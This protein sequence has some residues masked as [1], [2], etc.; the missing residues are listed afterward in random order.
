MSPPSVLLMN[1]GSTSADLPESITRPDASG[2]PATVSV[3][4]DNTRASAIVALATPKDRDTPQVC[5]FGRTCGGP[6]MRSTDIAAR[7]CSSG[8]SS[9]ELLQR[10][11]LVRCVKCGDFVRL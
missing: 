8:R 11:D 6:G 9:L 4:A 10:A 1:D 5:L 3:H 2:T 7:K